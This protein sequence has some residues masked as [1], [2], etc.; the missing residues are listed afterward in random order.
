MRRLRY[1]LFLALTSTAFAQGQSSATRE[2]FLRL[3]AFDITAVPPESFAL[4]PA[5]PPPVTP[6]AAPI[7]GYLNHEGTTLKLYGNE[8]IFSKSANAEDA[9]KTELH[10]AKVNLPKTGNRFIL[11]FLPSGNNTYRV[12]PLSDT[13]KDFPLGSY[14]VISLS[15]LPIKLTLEDKPYEFNPGDSKL[16][17][18]PPVQANNHSAMYCFAQ[19]DGKWQ[20][21]AAGLWPHPGKKRSV[22]VFFDNPETQQTEL[23][24]FKDISPPSAS[25]APAPGATPSPP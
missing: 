25:S 9:K 15:R 2:V 12:L 16:I 14:R 4:D 3:L 5:A 18:D 17:E 19:K 1:L 7:K 10:L 13:V 20:K 8:I 11:V 24:G 23:R 21:I 6:L 22:E